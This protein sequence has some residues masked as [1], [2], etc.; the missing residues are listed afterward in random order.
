MN[1]K[2]LMPHSQTRMHFVGNVLVIETPKFYNW[3]TAI[4][5]PDAAADAIVIVGTH[6][7]K[8]KRGRIIRRTV[9]RTAQCRREEDLNA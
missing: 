1:N 4:G 9:A 8:R 3:L 6:V 7:D 5:R 2:L